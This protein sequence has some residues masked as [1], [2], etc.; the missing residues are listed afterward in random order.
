[1]RSIII[2]ACGAL[3][4]FSASALAQEAYRCVRSDGTVVY[5]NQR[6]DSLCRQV[7]APERFIPPAAPRGVTYTGGTKSSSRKSKSSRHANATPS[8]A[9]SRIEPHVQMSRDEKRR[10]ILEEELSIEQ[11]NLSSAKHQYNQRILELKKANQPESL[12]QPLQDQVM[13]H[14]RNIEALRRELARIK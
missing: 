14:Q 1:M 10:S 11:K 3:S 12:A 13:S 5:T 6:D 7:S 8:P 4:L 2:A 9:G